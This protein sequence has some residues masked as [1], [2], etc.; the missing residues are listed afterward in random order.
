M[1]RA[2]WKE[3]AQTRLRAF[4][5]E[6]ERWSAGLLYGGLAASAVF[7]LVEAATG[8]LATGNLGAAISVGSLAAS[9]VGGNLLA[10]QIS[11]WHDRTEA[12]IAGELAV[13]AEADPA[14]R[15]A[16]DELL[17]A[18]ETPR[19]VQAV[20]P[21]RDWDRFQRLLQS[22]L[23]K[24]GNGEK[25]ASYFIDTGG[26][27]YVG[28]D[29]TVTKGDFVGRD[30]Y[31]IHNHPGP[32][33]PAQA[34]AAIAYRRYLDATHRRC[35]VLPLAPLGGEEST[36]DEVTLAQVYIALDTQSRVKLTAKEKEARKKAGWSVQD[37]AERP[38]SVLEA[39]GRSRRLV[40][41]GDPGSG[42]STFVRQLCAWHA[43]ALLGQPLPVDLPPT[44]PVHLLPLFIIIREVAGELAALPLDGVAVEEGDRRLLAVLWS[45]WQKGLDNDRAADFAEALADRLEA[46]EV[47]LVL[48]GLDEAPVDQ[49]PAVVR[50]IAALQRS[51]PKVA[52]LIVTCRVRSYTD[53]VR[54]DGFAA[55][56]LASFDEEKIRHFARAWYEAQS[57][58][59]RFD[60][61]TADIR[62]RDLAQ[63]AL[64]DK[65]DKLSPNPMLLTT[66]VIV[67]QK[68]T[69]LPN[70]R[71][72]LYH[73][74]VEV[75]AQ[76][77]QQQRGLPIAPGLTDLF[78]NSNRLRRVLERLAYEAHCAKEKE[79]DLPRTQLLGILEE[80]APDFLG[81][82]GLASAFL[83]YVDQRAGLLVGQGGDGSRKHPQSYA[84]PHLTFQ[85]YLAG[86]YLIDGRGARRLYWEKVA[87]GDRWHLAGMYG[88]EELLHNRRSA[89]DLL[90]LL[91]DLCPS[92]A[93]ADERSWR[94][95]VWSGQ[96]AALLGAE[97]IRKD[98]GAPN[99]GAAYLE[100][101]KEGLV[102]LL[103]Q[104]HLTSI[105][106]AEGGRALGLLGDSRP[107]VGLVV[108]TG[109]PDIDWIPI[110]PGPFVMGGKESWEGGQ[111]FTCHLITQPYRIARYPVTVAQY[112]CF[113]RAGGYGERKWWTAAGWQW[114]EKAEIE[115]PERYREVFQ[116]P[117]HPVV[118]VSWYEAVAYCAWLSEQVGYQVTLPS[119]AQFER[120]AR[121]TDGRIYPWNGE[122]APERCNA[123][124]T[125]I[126][127]T[128][129]VG[130][131][132]GGNAECGAVDMAGN[133]WEWCSSAWLENYAGYEQ[134]VS[135]DL[136]G[137]DRRVLRGGS[138]N[139]NRDDTRCA[140][141]FG[142]DPDYRLRGFG[143]R[144][145]SPGS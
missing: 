2:E 122:F 39:A 68:E 32:P 27:A 142:L 54:L 66:M 126:D 18:L 86:C 96:M 81:D 16:L 90:D 22:E 83:D 12:E 65:L 140:S 88:A 137:D 139:I 70:E 60:R 40:L 9:L 85:E 144:L 82:A 76:R 62:S 94:A 132:P 67:H 141:R 80:P 53:A 114:R 34:A 100:R 113:V 55:E 37:D 89:T 108:K 79:A 119:E 17:L 42:K 77:W 91:Y 143:F 4:A 15:D 21:E 105:E 23:T 129:A 30:K 120:A 102:A 103:T 6:T 97:A 25:Y 109:L 138:F 74:A 134:R 107:G 58:L 31:E 56:T 101:V 29:T 99:G 5:S 127:A 19:I 92:A 38:V 106:R 46:G 47:L 124:E 36:G 57:R 123:S 51:Y 35:N 135:N 72:K 69:K 104:T 73:K 78:A 28:G 87:E 13:S 50:A 8:A 116:T 52:R 93:P 41:L 20:L 45:H 33:D 121:H 112:D 26:G 75:L 117:N 61:A 71:V 95:L 115:G 111:Q 118:G 125:G 48:D 59:G 145:L 133:V 64:S 10:E 49:R 1:N 128:S 7:P 110:S 44:W 136:T 24:L 130:I 131:F 3:S 11:R 98:T 43:L 14:W 63:A 84:F